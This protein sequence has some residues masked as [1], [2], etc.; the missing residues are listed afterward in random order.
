MT[1]RKYH[2]ITLAAVLLATA[3]VLNSPFAISAR[4]D[5]FYVSCCAQRAIETFSSTGSDLGA[6]AN[7]GNG[8]AGLTFDG[9]AN[10][11]VADASDNTIEKF[12]S[13]GVG[14]A[15]LRLGRWPGFDSFSNGF[16][17]RPPD[18]PGEM[19]WV[20]ALDQGLVDEPSLAE[21]FLSLQE[22]INDNPLY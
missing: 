10:L 20:Q 21:A 8:A 13:G 9:T 11:F 16:F 1:M 7:T 19:H 22:C 15:S 3:S 14:S 5:I 4:A 2:G 17:Q 12:T 6:F 18:L